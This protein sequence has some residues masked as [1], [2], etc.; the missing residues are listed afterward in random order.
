MVLSSYVGATVRRKEDPRLIT[1]SST[2]VDDIH[3][4]NTLHVAFVRSPYAHAKIN[5]IDASAALA[6][7]GVRAV[8]TAD[9]L[10]K[11]LKDIY[12]DPPGSETGEHASEEI[13][14]E[15]GIPVPSVVPLATDRV[16]YVGDPVAAI[17]ADSACDRD[18]RD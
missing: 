11:I 6:L 13:A 3:L 8:V 17:V 5:G 18:R 12:P 2:Y 16:R 14:A 9:D 7:A 15:D 1:G 10:K 4:P